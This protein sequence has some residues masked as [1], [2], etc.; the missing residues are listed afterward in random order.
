MVEASTEEI[1]MGL[2]RLGLFKQSSSLSKIEYQIT[3][4]S[5]MDPDESRQVDNCDCPAIDDV[6][7]LRV[8][9]TLVGT[10]AS[11]LMSEYIDKINSQYAA[12]LKQRQTEP[13]DLISMN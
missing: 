6:A 9:T 5:T 1:F 12:A 8:N 2:R 11:K 4:E 13:I 3:K 7:S 10:Q